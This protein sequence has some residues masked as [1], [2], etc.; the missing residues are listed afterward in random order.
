MK[1]LNLITLVLV[2]VGALNWGL[3][4]LFNFNLV[5]A[6]FGE[7]SSLARLVYA[8]VGL[9]ALWQLIPLVTALRTDEVSAMRGRSPN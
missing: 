9:S 1:S 3:V 2:I 5:A 7:G 4:G 6:I 8:L